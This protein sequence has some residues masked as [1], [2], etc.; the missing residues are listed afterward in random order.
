MD[1]SNP[2]N[3]KPPDIASAS[4]PDTLAMLHVN[5]DTGLR[6]ARVDVSR[7]ENGWPKILR[8]LQ[9]RL[10]CG[11]LGGRNFSS[12]DCSLGTESHPNPVILSGL[13]N[14]HFLPQNRLRFAFGFEW[15][16]NRNRTTCKAPMSGFVAIFSGNVL[17]SATYGRV[18]A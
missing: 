1:P 6:Q 15:T 13:Q 2:A 4:V 7:K 10:L 5:P 17:L 18:E 8:L 3:P 14:D 12:C 11:S 9:I 16:A